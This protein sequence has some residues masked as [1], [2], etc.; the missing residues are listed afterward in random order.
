MLARAKKNA[1][2]SYRRVEREATLRGQSTSRKSRKQ[3]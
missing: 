3:A 1:A 2:R